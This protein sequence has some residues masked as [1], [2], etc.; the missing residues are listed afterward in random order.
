MEAW[1]NAIGEME[2][3]RPQVFLRADALRAVIKAP[4]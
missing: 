4:N 2:L 3:R 1:I